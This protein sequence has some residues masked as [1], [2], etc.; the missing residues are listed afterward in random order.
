M[1]ICDTCCEQDPSSLLLTELS[2]FSLFRVFFSSSFSSASLRV[3]A[4]APLQNAKTFWGKMSSQTWAIQTHFDWPIGSVS[5]QLHLDTSLYD[6]GKPAP[7]SLCLSN[8]TKCV[9]QGGNNNL[10]AIHR[11]YL[12][13][14]MGWKRFVSHVRVKSPSGPF[15]LIKLLA[16]SFQHL[17]VNA[18]RVALRRYQIDFLRA[19]TW[20]APG[21]LPQWC[22]GCQLVWF[23]SLSWRPLRQKNSRANAAQTFGF[24]RRPTNQKIFTDSFWT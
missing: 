7:L 22:A 3:Q 20:P 16:P 23:C 18:V 13:S 12:L 10:L 8:W 1:C 5:N 19:D 6:P 2:S 24:P 17:H 4:S 21:S 11:I 14:R 15:E 9:N